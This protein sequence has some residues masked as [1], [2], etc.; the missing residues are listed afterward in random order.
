MFVGVQS[1]STCAGIPKILLGLSITGVGWRSPEELKHEYRR[2]PSP[3]DA[4]I[5]SARSLF[6]P[7]HSQNLGHWRCDT[8]T[9]TVRGRYI[10][11]S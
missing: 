8:I 11:A 1:L 6:S 4:Q 7:F 10:L 3:T 5:L 9:G 2:P